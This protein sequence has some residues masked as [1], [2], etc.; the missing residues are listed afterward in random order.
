[1]SSFEDVHGRRRREFK[2]LAGGLDTTSSQHDTEEWRSFCE[3][4]GWQSDEPALAGDY[5][6]QLVARIFGSPLKLVEPAGRHPSA[7]VSCE[8]AR[9]DLYD[10]PS[11]MVGQPQQD[12]GSSPTPGWLTAL[13]VAA[14][15]GIACAAMLSWG[16]TPAAASRFADA[17]FPDLHSA[18][19]RPRSD[20]HSRRKSAC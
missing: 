3:Q 19:S 8:Q 14:V 2:L 16:Q 4:I 6:D 15:V 1:M 12:L 10:F 13:A 9:N 17:V 11:K 7:S 5:D 20:R 18:P